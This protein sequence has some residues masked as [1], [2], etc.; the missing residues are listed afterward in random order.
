MDKDPCNLLMT[1]VEDTV[2]DFVS[3]ITKAQVRFSDDGM[4]SVHSE[5][6]EFLDESDAID[7]ET[8]GITL[9]LILERLEGLEGKMRSSNGKGN[10]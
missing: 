3:D 7:H 1:V 10:F 8:L 5:V 6:L 2:S 4:M 9:S